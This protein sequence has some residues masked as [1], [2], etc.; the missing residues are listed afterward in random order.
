MTNKARTIF[1]NSVFLVLAV[2]ASALCGCASAPHVSISMDGMRLPNQAEVAHLSVNKRDLDIAWYY[3]LTYHTMLHSQ[4]NNTESIIVQKP[5][6]MHGIHKLPSDVVS[7]GIVIMIQN[8]TLLKY[9]LIRV[10]TDNNHKNT[11]YICYQGIK[12]FNQIFVEGVLPTK[13]V[14]TLGIKLELFNKDGSIADSTYIGDLRYYTAGQTYKL[15]AAKEATADN[16]GTG[17]PHDNAA[18]RR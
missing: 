6:P 8:P 14:S 11:T 5:L 18:L 9:R 16:P 2:S 10:E 1:P 4:D 15:T 3:L 7:A 17:T 13:K 12:P